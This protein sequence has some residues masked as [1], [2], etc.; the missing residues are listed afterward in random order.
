MP[1]PTGNKLIYAAI[2]Y[3]GTPYEKLDCQG[4][5]KKAA[6]DCNI[7]VT[8]RGS[9]DMW[10]N[11]CHERSELDTAKRPPIGALLFTVVRDGKEDKTRYKDG[12]NARHVGL[13]CG[14]LGDREIIHST[15]GGVQ[16]DDWGSKRWT[17]TALLDG[18]DYGS[19]ASVIARDK[20]PDFIKEL[21]ALIEKYS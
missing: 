11:K 10:R 21:K 13:Y 8:W 14:P 17:H 18:V 3:I 1:T 12:I 2:K 6:R 20:L 16:W 9:N 15:A 4:L 7:N 19:N 5:I